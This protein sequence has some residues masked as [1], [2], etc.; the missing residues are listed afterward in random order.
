LERNTL[1]QEQKENPFKFSFTFTQTVD[2][3]VRAPDTKVASYRINADYGDLLNFNLG[4]VEEVSQEYLD[5]ALERQEIPK[6]AIN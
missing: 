3:F 5:A 1:T 2:G 4:S 6:E